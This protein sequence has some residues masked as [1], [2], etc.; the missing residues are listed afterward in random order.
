MSARLNGQG[1]LAGLTSVVTTT[2]LVVA[3]ALAVALALVPRLLGGG[4]LTVL[5]GSMEPTLSPGDMVVV[6]PV[7]VGDVGIGDVVTFQPVSDDPT[8]ITHRVVAKQ[9][10]SSGTTFVTRG[11]ANGADDAP[12]VADQIMGEV[13][14]HV[15]Y[16][17]HL[18]VWAGGS[19]QGIVVATGAALLTYA[20]FMLL[21][22]QRRTI[23]DDG[24]P[25]PGP[26]DDGAP[27]PGAP[28]PEEAQGTETAAGAGRATAEQGVPS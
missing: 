28:D 7:E 20:A 11:D 23:P 2:V 24:A 6:R 5:T 22:P 26:T 25:G 10:G 19:R 16:V 4:A 18:A 15:P 8:L 27:G 3:V 9:V 21:R 13:V 17:G 12:I 14:Y 1:R